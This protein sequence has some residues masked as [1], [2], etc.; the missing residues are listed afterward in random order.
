MGLLN[1]CFGIKGDNC[2]TGIYKIENSINH[3]CYIGQAKDIHKRWNRHRTEPFNTKG[4]S[5]N[6]PLYRAIRKYGLNN[7]TFEI[8][9]ECKVSELNEKEIFYIK[10]F[11]TFF[12][13]YNQTFG[14]DNTSV[15]DK[16]IVIGIIYDLENTNLFHREIAEKW[17]IS[18][19]MVQGIN[20][21]RYWKHD[22]EYPIQIKKK[23]LIKMV[24]NKIVICDGH[25]K[26]KVFCKDCGKE[27]SYGAKRCVDCGYKN[28]R[29][30]ERP[31]K[32]EL[33]NLLK[34]YKNF[35]Y[36]ANLFNVSDNAVKKWCKQYGIP[37]LIS[38]YIEKIKKVKKPYFPKRPIHMIDIKTN[39]IIKTFSSQTEAEME[40][41]GKCTGYI[42]K[43]L[44]G[45]NSSVY[46]YKWKYA[47][48]KPNNT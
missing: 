32:E 13:G 14:G 11:D 2:I 24:N 40:L 30:C 12:N 42:T 27:I 44:S 22:R 26:E 3:K 10:K 18:T 35:T 5:Y 9:E 39:K 46:G 36:I 47:D 16:Q 19:E 7:F 48:E 15:I 41:R 33:Y 37:H 34:E 29:K 1:H 6:Y 43:A 28:S 31:S 23:P 20:T 4:P 8:L 25:S 45:K 38:N 21:G 17:N